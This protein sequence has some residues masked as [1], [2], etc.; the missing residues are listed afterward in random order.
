MT[1]LNVNFYK[2]IYYLNE[3]TIA[4]SISCYAPDSHVLNILVEFWGVELTLR[5]AVEK[6]GE[7]TFNGFVKKHPSELANCKAKGIALRPGMTLW[8]VTI[9]QII[10]N[11]ENDTWE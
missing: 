3:N 8:D 11:P 7:L 4:H 5:L 6:N 9:K 1:K 10:D 2:V